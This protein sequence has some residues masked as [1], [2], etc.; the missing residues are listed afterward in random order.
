[1]RAGARAPSP[2]AQPEHGYWVGGAARAGCKP[3]PPSI[4]PATTRRPPS[5]QHQPGNRQRIVWTRSAAP[6]RIAP[7]A[8][9]LSG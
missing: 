1:M 3:V 9:E 7:I 8:A 5:P 2:V 6:P 4:C